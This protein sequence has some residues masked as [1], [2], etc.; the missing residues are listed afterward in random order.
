[1]LGKLIIHEL[2]KK[3]KSSRYVLLGYGAVQL[4]LLFIIRAFL[5]NEGLMDGFRISSDTS[6]NVSL[7][8]GLLTTL[9]LMLSFVI[10]AYP[11]VES[12]Y[13]FERDLSGKQAYL[14]LM[15][16]A[17]AWQKVLSK[18]IATLASLAVCGTISLFSM[19]MFITV[20]SNFLYFKE[21]MKF[22]AQVISNEFLTCIVAIVLLLFAFASLYIMIFL[23]IAVAKSFTHKNTVAVPVGILVFILLTAVL[24]IADTQINRFPIYTFNLLDINFSVSMIIS[25]II[26]FV[27]LLVGTSWL[28]EKRIE[29]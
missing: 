3:W 20:N 8:F 15:I 25:N 4:L 14:E 5:W 9:F 19:F 11:F 1:M 12:M 17:A 27:L 29:H 10:G 22:V 28:I 2:R 13:R 21:F 26:T 7:G 18:L 24:A 23:C 6:A 16:P